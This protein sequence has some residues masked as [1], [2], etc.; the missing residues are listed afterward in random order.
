MSYGFAMLIIFNSVLSTIDYFIK[1]MPDYQ[2]SFFVSFGFNLLVMV[3]LGIVILR[4]YKL[5]F[6]V[7]NNLMMFVSIPLALLMPLTS[8]YVEKQSQKFTLF[9]LL[10][11]VIGMVNSFQQ[12][13][14]YG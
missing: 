1:S 10:L 2:P 7:K 12:G 5:P 8:E 13:S 11:V 14:L 3:F 4:G 9:V 6:A